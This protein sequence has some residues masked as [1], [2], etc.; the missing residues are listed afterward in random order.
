MPQAIIRT[1]SGRDFDVFNP[2]PDLIHI[3]DI[4]HALSYMP[5]FCGHTNEF[6]SVARHS[7]L[8]LEAV[9]KSG[10]SRRMQLAAL[11]HDASEAYLMDIPSPIKQHLPEYKTIENRLMTVIAE[12]YGFDYPL[13]PL[14]HQFDKASCELEFFRYMNGKR[15]SGS[16]VNHF[17]DQ[18]E[19]QRRY[20]LL[21]FGNP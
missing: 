11:L 16:P 6:C 20:D 5:R 12:K 1:Y 8:I 17:E 14:I 18:W 9:K 21:T 4:A 3:E 10:G 19:F 7:M 15:T 2:N 13:H